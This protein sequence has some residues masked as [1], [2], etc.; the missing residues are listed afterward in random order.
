MSEQLLITQCRH[1]W[2]ERKGF[3]INRPHGLREGTFLHFLNEVEILVQGR[4]LRAPAGSLIFYA[5][6]TPQW[7]ESH[8]ELVHNWLHTSGDLTQAL[9]QV[10]LQPDTLYLPRNGQFIT[11]ILRE[12]EGELLSGRAYSQRIIGLKFQELLIKV[13]RACSDTAPLSVPSSVKE[14][15]FLNLR[16]QMFGD[17]AHNWTVAELAALAHLSPS[18]FYDVYR[19]IFHI[20]PTADLIHARIDRARRLLRD[21]DISIHALAEQLGYGNVTHF[22]RQFKQCAGVTP[23]QYRA[24]YKSTAE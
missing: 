10:G 6:Q 21:T 8:T 11:D 4:R 2:P 7:F 15:L 23:S 14:E 17:L 5:P 1:S 20:S 22:C 9:E 13:A 16:K 12:M 18:R 3:I 24:G 19:A